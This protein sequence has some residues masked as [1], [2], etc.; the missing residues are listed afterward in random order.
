MRALEGRVQTKKTPTCC[1]EQKWHSTTEAAA[2]SGGGHGAS[3]LDAYTLLHATFKMSL[4][5]SDAPRFCKA[6]MIRERYAALLGRYARLKACGQVLGVPT[7][8]RTIY[9]VATA[10][11]FGASFLSTVAR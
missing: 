11:R 2:A 7:P 5:A 8:N 10:C 9:N 3:V 4:S 6:F 1:Y